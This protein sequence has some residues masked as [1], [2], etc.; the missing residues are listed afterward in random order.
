[1]WKYENVKMKKQ[2]TQ[3]ESLIVAQQM[4]VMRRNDAAMKN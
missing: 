1:M 3:S 4:N 2:I